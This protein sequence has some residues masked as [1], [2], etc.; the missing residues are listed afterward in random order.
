[1]QRDAARKFYRDVCQLLWEKWD[2]IGVNGLSNSTDE[3]DSYAGT[4]CRLLLE[5]RDEHSLM[6]YLQNVQRNSMGLSSVDTECDRR[7]VGLL[8]ELT[9]SEVETDDTN[10]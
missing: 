3:Y 9:N 1:M 7:V 8:L 2:P 5:G 10:R 4:L 6:A